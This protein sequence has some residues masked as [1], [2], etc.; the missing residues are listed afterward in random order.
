[1]TH[2]VVRAALGP[3]R[4]AGGTSP[5]SAASMGARVMLP[6]SDGQRYLGPCAWSLQT[7]WG[8]EVAVLV[9]A[10]CAPEP[11]IALPI[12]AGLVV[13]GPFPSHV[14]RASV[15]IRCSD[16]GTLDAIVADGGSLLADISAGTLTSWA[17]DG[18]ITTARVEQQLRAQAIAYHKNKE[19]WKGASSNEDSASTL[20]H[21][22]EVLK[23][24]SSIYGL[25]QPE[26]DT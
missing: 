14:R 11:E 26:T 7:L 23:L 22:D 18:A 8:A 6:P 16:R 13:D 19:L 12:A 4:G 25:P 17:L 3:L 10:V 5:S 15:Q 9:S 21:A 24:L 20:R 2:A 1:M